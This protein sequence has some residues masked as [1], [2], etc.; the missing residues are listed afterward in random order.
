M[1]VF[2]GVVQR[3]LIAP[4]AKIPDRPFTPLRHFTIES[5]D[6]FIP[7]ETASAQDVRGGTRLERDKL[8]RSHS[9]AYVLR[10]SDSKLL[11]RLSLDLRHGSLV[12][13]DFNPTTA[14]I[15]DF[16]DN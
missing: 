14:V 6:V 12:P 15:R 8:L 2:A 11:P 4:G 3:D 1:L 5:Q 10:I 16:Q 13:I 7:I 9:Q